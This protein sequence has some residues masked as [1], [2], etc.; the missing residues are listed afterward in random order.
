MPSI[1]VCILNFTGGR[2]NWGCQ[3][4]SWEFAKF[5]RDLWDNEPSAKLTYVPLLPRTSLDLQIAQECEQE[6][7]DVLSRLSSDSASPSDCAFLEE[8]GRRRF[9]DW[10]DVVKRA[11]VVILQTEGSMTGTDFVRGVR[12]LI[13]PS[14]AKFI[15]RKKV[16]ALNQTLFSCDNKFSSLVASVFNAFDFVS[17]RDG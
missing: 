4:T 1:E 15:W 6:L 7:F 8:V 16:L 14:L 2:A 17:V 10:C 11:D 9:G 3:A 12:L 13:L 5:V